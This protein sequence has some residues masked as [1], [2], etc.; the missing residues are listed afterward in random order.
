MAQ[1]WTKRTGVRQLK[2]A[3]LCLG[4]LLFASSFSFAQSSHQAT[5]L[6]ISDGDTVWVLMDGQRVKLR[7]LGIDTP[8]KFKSKKLS[9]DARECGVSQGYMK[10]LG[11]E[12]TYYA[13]SLLHKGQKVRVVVYGKGYYGRSLALIYLLDGTCYNEK[14]IK[15]GYACVYE[16]SREL[17][18]TI[19]RKFISLE[20][21]AKRDRRGLWRSHYQI[22]KCL[23][24]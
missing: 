7:L 16:K 6:K 5:I 8:E 4:V 11:Q 14:I 2:L 22:L 15:D 20:Q 10:N 18:T 3:L 13:K 17:P 1:T 19:M 9:R 12:A 24:Q 21:E 23:C